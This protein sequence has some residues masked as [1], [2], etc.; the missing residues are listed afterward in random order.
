MVPSPSQPSSASFPNGLFSFPTVWL[1]AVIECGYV[2]TGTVAFVSCDGRYTHDLH[3]RRNKIAASSFLLLSLV[4]VTR[5]RLI[6]ITVAF[7]S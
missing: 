3:R 7:R 5:I 6:M 1:T 4:Q 2:Q